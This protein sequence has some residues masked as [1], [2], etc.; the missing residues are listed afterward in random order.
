[1]PS[2]LFLF[3]L[4]AYTNLSIEA[5]VPSITLKTATDSRQ[6]PRKGLTR[7]SMRIFTPAAKIVAELAAESVTGCWCFPDLVG[8]R[9]RGL[10]TLRS[11][12]NC[13]VKLR[14]C[15]RFCKCTTGWY[16]CKKKRCE[17]CRITLQDDHFVY[18][19]EAIL[20]VKHCNKR[21]C[22]LRRR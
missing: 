12:G 18:H 14:F 9:G 13:C 5:F 4:A 8:C 7:R 19:L 17:L 20:T 6:K 21:P 15:R 2:L 10:N 16:T 11:L 22:T 3:P 1:M